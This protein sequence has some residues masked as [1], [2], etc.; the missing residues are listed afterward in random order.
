MRPATFL[1][2]R[3]ADVFLALSSIRPAEVLE[4]PNVHA[5][6]TFLYPSFFKRIR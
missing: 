1:H 2:R 5:V 4:R 6:S 3:K